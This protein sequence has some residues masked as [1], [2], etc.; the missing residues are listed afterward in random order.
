MYLERVDLRLQPLALR[1]ALERRELR[2]ELVALVL[3]RRRTLA[4]ARDLAMETAAPGG[5]GGGT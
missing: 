3:R 2:R 1:R 4:L 5:G